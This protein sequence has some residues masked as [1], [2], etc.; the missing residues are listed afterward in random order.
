MREQHQPGFRTAVAWSPL[1]RLNIESSYCKASTRTIWSANCPVLCGLLG[2]ALAVDRNFDALS[3]LERPKG[4]LATR[5]GAGEGW[6]LSLR[7]GITAP[8]DRPNVWTIKASGVPKIDGNGLAA[9]AASRAVEGGDPGQNGQ[10][11]WLDGVL[12]KRRATQ[13]AVRFIRSRPMSDR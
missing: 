1:A 11:R 6:W 10:N 3:G 12:N 7:S 9:D 8:G 5:W 2:H 13:A 4:P